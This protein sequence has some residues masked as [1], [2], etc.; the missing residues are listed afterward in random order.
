MIVRMKKC[1]S[2]LLA[3]AFYFSLGGMSLAAVNNP[4]I[5]MSPQWTN[6]TSVNVNL[7]FDDGKGTCGARVLGK[8][9]TT[10]I[11]GKVVLARKNSDGT[12]T[13]VKTWS[14]LEATGEKL[15]FDKTYYV[16]TGYSYR[17]TITAT[18]YR[19]GTGETVSGSYEAYAQ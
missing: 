17:L 5:T 19:N 15:L 12:Y 2:L 1:T 10:K 13:A 7:S 6:T 9:G 8:S 3:L 16:T 18:V 4:Q 14:D 11:T